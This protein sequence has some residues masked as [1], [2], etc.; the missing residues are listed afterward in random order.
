MLLLRR[1]RLGRLSFRLPLIFLLSAIE[2]WPSSHWADEGERWVGEGWRRERVSWSSQH[3]KL[4]AAL[5]AACC[6]VWGCHLAKINC[7]KRKITT[8]SQDERATKTA[9]Q[10]I[11]GEKKSRRRSRRGGGAGAE[12]AGQMEKVRNTMARKKERGKMDINR[13][14]RYWR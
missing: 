14:R 12:R 4:S 1:R 3:N 9:G 11:E 5:P 8:Q 10:K 13:L 7:T 2:Q 6:P